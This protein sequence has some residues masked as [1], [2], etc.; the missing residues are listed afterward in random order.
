MFVT[1]GLV[2]ALLLNVVTATGRNKMVRN[3]DV[4]QT[5]FIY[6]SVPNPGEDSTGHGIVLLCNVP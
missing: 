1:G 4:S 2:E 6:F 5:D 3:V